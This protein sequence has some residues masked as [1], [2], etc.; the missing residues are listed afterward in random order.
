MTA[1]SVSLANTK[2]LSATTAFRRTAHGEQLHRD[3][4]E[5][6][7]AD[8]DDALAATATGAAQRGYHPCGGLQQSRGFSRDA[9]G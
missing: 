5:H 4:S 9:I 6:A 8:D 3:Q 2:T 7:T 1:A